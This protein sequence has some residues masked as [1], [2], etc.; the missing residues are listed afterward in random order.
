MAH[1]GSICRFHLAPERGGE[2]ALPRRGL[3]SDAAVTVTGSRAR[4]SRTGPGPGLSSGGVGPAQGEAWE[5]AKRW[6]RRSWG[7]DAQAGLGE[8]GQRQAGM[9]E[10]M[11][12]GCRE[13]YRDR[14]RQ[15]ADRDVGRDAGKD[16]GRDAG[17]DKGRDAVRDAG[18]HK[19]GCREG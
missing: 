13:G 14:C 6:G 11:Q 1:S 2:E 8:M 4:R 16:A 12:E 3:G 9:Q 7:G 10:G 15:G 17:R 5:A 18:L 19:E